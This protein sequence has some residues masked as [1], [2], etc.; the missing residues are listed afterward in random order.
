MFERTRVVRFLLAGSAGFSVDA[1]L[2]SVLANALDW[3]PYT[4]RAVSFP[5]AMAVTWYLNR[6]VT[7][8]DRPSTR[9]GSE[10]ARYVAVQLGGAAVNYGVF[11]AV[12]TL[13][14]QAA[15][16]PVLA[17]VPAAAAAICFTY[18][19]MHYFAFP[20]NAAHHGT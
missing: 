6:T 20:H 11:S 16:W 3:S 2:L 18:V 8:R 12:V 7:F 4:A 15:R 5:I 14:D 13:S 10:L 17:L 9:L 1:L 19:G